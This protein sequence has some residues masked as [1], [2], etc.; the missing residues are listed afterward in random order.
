VVTDP[1]TG[2]EV[3]RPQTCRRCS[4]TIGDECQHIRDTTPP[5]VYGAPLVDAGGCCAEGF[6]CD[7]GE[8]LPDRTTV[9]D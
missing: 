3:Q 8:C 7:G 4:S 6:H 5:E 2:D 9:C 1:T